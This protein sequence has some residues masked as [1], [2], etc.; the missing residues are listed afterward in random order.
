MA[1]DDGDAHTLGLLVDL[2]NLC[3]AIGKSITGW[4]P[5]TRPS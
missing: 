2:R 3:I 1:E 4:R 5:T